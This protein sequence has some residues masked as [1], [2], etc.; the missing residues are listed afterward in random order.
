MTLFSV[1]ETI[2]FD[3]SDGII[4]GG[5]VGFYRVEKDF[6]DTDVLAVYSGD[7]WCGLFIRFLEEGGYVSEIMPTHCWCPEER[8]KLHEAAW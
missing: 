1:G 4:E 6:I 2:Q 5:I 8:G 7:P 3:W